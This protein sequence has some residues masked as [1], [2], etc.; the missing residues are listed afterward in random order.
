MAHADEGGER[1]EG[2][3]RHLLGEGGQMR[4]QLLIPEWGRRR[5]KRG[6]GSGEE[7]RGRGRR[8]IDPG[9]VQPERGEGRTG[10]KSFCC[11]VNGSMIRFRKGRGNRETVTWGRGGGGRGAVRF[12]RRER[13]GYGKGGDGQLTF[14]C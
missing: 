6:G 10:A 8:Y 14:T 1:G 7:G 13:D 12:W 3:D 4:D 2:G 9:L 5:W 11:D